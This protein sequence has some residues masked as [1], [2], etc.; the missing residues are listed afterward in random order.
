M[1]TR[2]RTVRLHCPECQQLSLECSASGA[3]R[4]L[5][6]TLRAQA[7][8]CDPFGAWEDVWEEAREVLYEYG[9]GQR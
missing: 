8:L 9:E 4:C 3:G 2:E 1:A 5:T 6:V 7:C